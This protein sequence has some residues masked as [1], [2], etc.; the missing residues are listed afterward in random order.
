[1]MPEKQKLLPRLQEFSDFPE[2]NL[3]GD[4]REVV[5]ACIARIEEAGVSAFLAATP[6]YFPSTKNGER[7][8]GWCK[9]R[10]VP[11]TRWNLTLAFRDLSEEGQLEA[12]PPT[13]L[14]VVDKMAGVTLVREDALLEYQT[15]SDEA[16]A[17][18]KV[19][20][21]PNLSDHARKA[22]DRRLALLAGQQRRERSNLTPHYGQRVVL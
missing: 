16:T 10:G 12:A 13:P 14:P 3:A 2:Y 20:D 9:S 4:D 8:I 21:D 11:L 6:G 1:M 22:R 17:L 7:M 5:A 15:P 18:E 19:A